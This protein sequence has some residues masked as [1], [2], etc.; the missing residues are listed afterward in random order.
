MAELVINL[1]GD[2]RALQALQARLASPGKVTAAIAA[3]LLSLTEEAFEKEATP[4]AKWQSLA[5]STIAAREK[6]GHWPG[7][8][9]QISAGG[10]ASSVTPASTD[11]SASLSSSKPY[12][13][14]QQLGGMAGRGK[15][16]HIP[17]RPYMP[18]VK[19][20]SDYK[21]N[22]AGEQAIRDM[23]AAFIANS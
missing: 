16:T 1:A 17:S 20:G 3:E 21:L 11:Q 13:A 2:L 4:T 15:K 7:K 18:I 12:A 9:L 22:S 10:L 5:K 14:I 8:I 19:D 6:K 23:V